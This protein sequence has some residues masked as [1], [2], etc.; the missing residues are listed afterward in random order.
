MF[1]IKFKKIKQIYFC[2]LNILNLLFVSNKAS[3]IFVIPP[4]PPPPPVLKVTLTQE[5]SRV[6]RQQEIQASKNLTALKDLSKKY[7]KRLN[8]LLIEATN[9]LFKNFNLMKN[10]QKGQNLTMLL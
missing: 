9:N 4:P 1:K 3:S 2:V 5:Q 8:E 6:L 10:Y 7:V